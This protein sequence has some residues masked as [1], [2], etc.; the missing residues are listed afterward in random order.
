MTRLQP[1]RAANPDLSW[2]ELVTLAY[3]QRVQLWAAAFY[4]TEGL[5]WDV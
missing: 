3:H 4:R 1:V 2:E 5:S